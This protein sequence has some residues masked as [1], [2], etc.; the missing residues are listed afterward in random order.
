MNV[1]DILVVI[2][3][4]GE[5]TLPLLLASLEE[6]MPMTHVHVLR[7]A[8]FFDAVVEMFRIGAKHPQ[9]PILLALDADVILAKNAI[10]II[11][12]Q[13]NQL[14]FDR[15]IRK[16]FQVNDKFYGRRDSGNHLYA[17]HWSAACH[18][19]FV[20]KGQPNIMRPESGNLKSLGKTKG[21]Y[22]GELIKQEIGTHD[23]HQY[24]KHIYVGASNLSKKMKY[25]RVEKIQVLERK[26]LF[27]PNDMDYKIAWEGLIME[28]EVEQVCTHNRQYPSVDHL[29][30]KYGIE[31]KS[32]LD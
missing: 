29:L 15:F 25:G 1:D 11:L 19:F 2:R 20:D 12:Q 7:I 32:P 8:P 3:S 17:N 28:A 21:L 24:Y 4:S 30:K 16:H 27:E 6:Q 31:E 5:R 13:A 10:D 26:M 14:D 18:E 23:Y 9:K 22:T